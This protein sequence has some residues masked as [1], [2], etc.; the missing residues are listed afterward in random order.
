MQIWPKQIFFLLILLGV[1]ACQPRQTAMPLNTATIAPGNTPTTAASL[2]RTTAP[3]ATPTSAILSALAN[4]SKRTPT[5]ASTQKP[6]I[7]Q[8]TPAQITPENAWWNET[9][10]YE[11]F[12]RSFK[13]S[14]GDGVGDIQGL[15]DKLDYLNDGNSDTTTDLGITGIW[16]MP[17]TESTSYHGYDIVDYYA[18][19]QEYGTQ[20]DFKQLIEAA[21]QRGIKVIIDLVINHTGVDNPWFKASQ[22]N[23][24]E[25]RDWYIWESTRPGYL[26]PW[27][28]PVW[29][30]SNGAYYYGIFWGGMPDLNLENPD[31]TQEIYEITRFWLEEMNVDGFRMDAIRHI[32]ENGAVQENTQETH[33]WLQGFHQYYK[34]VDPQAFTVGEAWTTTGQVLDYI[35]DEMDIAFEFDLAESFLNAAKGS[36][37][38]GLKKQAQKVLESY[39]QGQ[40]GVFLTYHDQNR[41]RFMLRS[42][43]KS[44][45]AATMLLTFPGVPFIYYG[46]EI[47]MLGSKPDEDIRLPMQWTG[48]ASG[49]GFTS[50]TPWRPPY[51]DY[52]TRNVAAEISDPASLWNH[53][54]ALIA[55]RNEYPA[56]R[57]GEAVLVEADTANLYAI[58]RYTENEAFLVLVN[59]YSKDLNTEQYALSLPEGL[60]FSSAEG[61]FT[62]KLN[63]ELV[64]G[65]AGFENPRAPILNDQGGFENYHPFDSIP[66]ESSAIIKLTP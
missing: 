10:F 60:T 41:V 14:D 6:T 36:I 39:P 63:A 44:R 53:Y 26:G 55:L 40:Y 9:V 54:R 1:S 2:V 48:E 49:A 32:I 19:D 46:E 4:Q 37:V 28:E 29:H 42:D 38:S 15:I 23:D 50:G 65:G 16:L 66:A 3:S 17:V 24:P 64:L 45:L 43:E 11:V 61:A 57:S 33:A 62:G 35:G 7:T 22:A 8:L 56:L 25:F 52:A 47:G 58:L 30:F 31:V 51:E 34:S 13:D 12:V 21:H 5:T 59:P 18:V 20:E 27:G